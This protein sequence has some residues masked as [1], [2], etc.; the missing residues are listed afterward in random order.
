LSVRNLRITASRNKYYAIFAVQVEVPE[1]KAIK[2]IIALDP[3]HKN[4]VY[5]VDTDGKAIE[6][7]SPKFT[8]SFSKR[9]DELKSKRDRCVK[10]SKKI[11]VLDEKGKSTGKEF[12]KP[13][14]RWEKFNIALQRAL[15]KR[16]EQTKTFAFTLAHR[17]CRDYDCVA[18]G[19]YTP[20]GDVGPHK[21]RRAMF[22]DSLIGKFKDILSWV[23]LK[24]GKT[25]VEYDEKG[26]TR[27]CNMCGFVCESGIAPNI[28][29]WCCPQCTIEHIRD[30]NAAQNGL[31]LVLK[32]LSKKEGM[33]VPLVP[34]SG[35]VQVNERWAW[36]VLPSGVATLCGG[37][38]GKQLQHQ[39]IQTESMGAFDRN[40][41]APV[42]FNIV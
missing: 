14:R 6:V 41:V 4:F 32:D 34:G 42:K 5:G 10:K 8:K 30:E 36:C 35:L 11:V 20:H 1:K 17:L 39:E 18:I 22:N 25:Y 31:R 2:Q 16:Q 12:F 33:N 9:I 21:M 19:N 38:N 26:T 3:N 23:A 24:S 7:A 29:K 15:Q 27:T 28:R 40:L 37:M 13:S